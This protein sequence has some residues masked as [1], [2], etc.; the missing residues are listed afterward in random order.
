MGQDGACGGREGRALH[1]EGKS[2][3]RPR[4][5]MQGT[6]SGALLLDSVRRWE[7]EFRG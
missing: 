1:T 7:E 5:G 3:Q 4:D 6:G 2:S